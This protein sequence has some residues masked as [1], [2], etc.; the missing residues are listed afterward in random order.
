VSVLGS[1]TPLGERSRGQ[2]WG[3]TVTFFTGGSLIGGA[4]IGA[5]LG[6]AGHPLVDLVSGSFGQLPLLAALATAVATG[7][8]FDLGM[9]GRHLPTTLRQVNREWLTR[10]RGWVY[11][12]G[13][14]FQ[15]GLG[16]VTI[17]TTSLTYLMLVASF[18]S[19]S[20]MAGL[21][22]GAVFGLT[23]GAVNLSVGRVR[24]LHEY[25]VINTTLRK[26]EPRSQ[27]LTTG[28]QLGVGLA[29]LVLIG[30]LA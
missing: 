19:G 26:W 6:G 24:E 29:M 8:V 23:R 18:L 9:F 1:I 28:I 27:R 2:K 22:I 3:I 30:I 10:Y 5:A 14:G 12:F 15:L 13:F 21:A 25:G 7:L 16:A 11:G 4:A 17:V 20:W